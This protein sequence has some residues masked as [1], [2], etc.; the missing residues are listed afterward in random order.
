MLRADWFLLPGRWLGLFGLRALFSATTSADAMRDLQAQ[1]I[2]QDYA[3]WGYWGPRPSKYTGWG[4]HSNRLI[5]VYT[6]GIDLSSVRGEH[7][8]YRSRERLE[9]LYGYLPTETLNP[10]AEYFDETDIYRL[11]QLAVAAGKEADYFGDFRR[12]G[13]ANDAGGGGVQ[14]RRGEVPR[15]ARERIAFSGLSGGA[16]GFWISSSRVRGIPARR[17]TW[18]RRR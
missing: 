11:Q 4:N 1:A 7:S 16:D 9:Q 8:P 17:W 2:Y 10:E 6:F 5:P 14:Q 18:M 15:R 3:E 12:D 13:L